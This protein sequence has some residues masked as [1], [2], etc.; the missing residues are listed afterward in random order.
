MSDTDPSRFRGWLS[1]QVLLGIGGLLTFVL[2]LVKINTIYDGLPA[3]PLFVHVPVILIPTVAVGGLIIAAKPRWFERHSVWL[4]TLTVIAL[5]S[6]N[7]TMNAGDALR[8]DLGLETGGGEVASLIA[9]HA[10]AAGILRVFLIAYTAVVIVAVAL[11]RERRGHRTEVG[12]IDAVLKRLLSV[13]GGLASVRVLMG[14]LALGC[15]Y[16]VFL[17]GD[18]GARA[19]W[20][21][22]VQAAAGFHGGYGPPPPLVGQ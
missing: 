3:H 15:L 17:T 7:L 4:C 18:L 2:I 21:G 8:A 5:A 20:Q 13:L 16:F 14:L 9:R 10:H 6:I 1:P 22:R 19:V 11:D 12:W